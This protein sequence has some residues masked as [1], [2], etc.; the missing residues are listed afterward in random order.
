MKYL[1]IKRSE[2]KLGEE[3]LIEAIGHDKGF[4]R[5]LALGAIIMVI[6]CVIGYVLAYGHSPS[7]ID[8]YRGKTTL[9]ITY[10]D[11][12]TIDSVVVYKVK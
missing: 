11:S 8:V 6:S 4:L 3:A 10:R 9:E 7:A 12:V 1:I 2:I 5:G